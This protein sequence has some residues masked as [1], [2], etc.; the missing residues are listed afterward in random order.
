MPP[1]GVTGCPWGRMG[2]HGADRDHRLGCL[3]PVG[4]GTVTSVPTTVNRD[5]IVALLRRQ[6][7]AIT[8]LATTLTDR[9]WDAPTCLPSWTVRDVLSHLVGTELMLSGHPPPAVDVSHLDHLQNSVAQA[10]EIW[11]ESMRWRSGSEMADLWADVAAERIVTLDGMSQ[12]EFDAPSWTPVGNDETYGRFMRI[13]HF[14]CYMH[15]HDM[16]FALGLPARADAED[17]ASCLDEVATGLGYIVG[18]RAELPDGSRVVI[19][20]TGVAARTFRIAVAGRATVV[21][22]L[23]GPATVGLQ[24]SVPLFLRL[25]GGRVDGAGGPGGE[26]ALSGHRDLARRL[27]EHLAFTI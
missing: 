26:I 13:R 22:A 7:A 25:T 15:E 10:N 11:V 2:P 12:H 17:Q 8:E 27:A 20:L 18:R 21:D 16:R 19:E 4:A 14:D 9:Q 6:F 5:Q 23:E 1:P 3:R 24:L